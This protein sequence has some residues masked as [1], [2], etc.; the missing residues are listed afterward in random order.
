MAANPNHATDRIGTD[1][2]KHL[3]FSFSIPAIVG[4]VVQALYNIVDRIYVGQGVGHIG[5][6]AIAVTMPLLMTNMAFSVIVGVGSNALFSIKLGEGRRDMVEKIMGNAF[7]LLFLVPLLVILPCLIFPR[8]I[9][10]AIGTTPDLLPYSERYLRILMYGGVFAAMSPGIN[11]FIRSDGHPRTSMFTQ[12]LGALLNTILDPI[13]IFVFHWGIEGAAWATIISQFASFVW[14]M[15]YFNSSLTPLRFKIRAMRLDLSL[16]LRILAIGFAPF[17]M[18]MAMNVMNLILNRQLLHYG[19][20][21]A[22]AVM[23]IVYSVIIMIM[24][25]LQGIN[26]G[27]QPIIGFNYGAKKIDRVRTAYW[28]AVRFATIFVTA[29]W[30]LIELIPGVFV[31]LFNSADHELI[32]LGSRAL[33]ICSAMM[34]IIGF[35]VITSNYFQAVGKPLQSTFLS[36]SRQFLILIPLLSILPPFWGVLGVYSALPMADV[37]SFVISIFI[38]AFELKALREMQ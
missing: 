30:L 29:G 1:N 32:L 8:Q 9:L 37:I 35:Q 15:S 5:L 27:A 25:P 36:L 7:L 38:M 11:H 22:V 16:V 4:M 6:A 17:S 13:F 33:R 12:L 24:M 10:T 19:G 3:L 34:P 14:V 20:D 28:L 21:M 23:G 26:Q 31:R 18:N 2:I